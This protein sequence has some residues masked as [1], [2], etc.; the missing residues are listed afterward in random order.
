MIK[1][2]SYNETSNVYDH[3][4]RK[5]DYKEWGIYLKKITKPFLKKNPAVLEIAGGTGK[6]AEILSKKFPD[7]LLTDKSCKMLQQSKIKNKI[8]MDFTTP[9]VNQKYDLILCTFD[10]VNYLLSKKKLLQLLLS[11]N[12]LL[13]QD[14]IFTFD[15]SLAKNSIQH[16]DESFRKHKF[17]NH[18]IIQL[19]SF[20]EFSKIHKNEFRFYSEN[21][22]IKKEIHKQKIYPFELYFN[23]INKSG[24]FVVE[25]FEC[26]TERKCKPN[27]KRAQ[28]IVK[29]N[30]C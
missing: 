28:F 22:L 8:V 19:S 30:R 4:M 1:Y 27:S 3:L 2:D 15:V 29:K 6:L 20:N 26:F 13:T 14:G 21:I 10:S 23:L 12:E 5:I 16:S 17:S 25:C 11:V 9:S 24:L 7:Y 18:K